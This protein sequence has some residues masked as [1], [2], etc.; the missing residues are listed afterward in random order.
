MGWAA[1]SVPSSA[2]DV[3][4]S[5]LLDVAND[6]LTWS[7]SN[8]GATVIRRQIDGAD[9]FYFSPHAAA[10]FAPIIETHSGGPCD[11]PRARELVPTSTSRM[12]L[13][14]KTRWEQFQPPRIPARG[15]PAARPK[16]GDGGAG[17]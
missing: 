9:R 16:G 2:G 14:F 5:Q 7:L 8:L 4:A 11:P 17:S 6:P 1:F 12:L 15:I 13:G 10:L 3:V